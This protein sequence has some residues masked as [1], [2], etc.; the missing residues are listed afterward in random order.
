MTASAGQAF[1]R[2]ARSEVSSAPDPAPF[3]ET[4][5]VTHRQ[6]GFDLLKGVEGHADDDQQR[7][8]AE[9][10]GNVQAIFNKIW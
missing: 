2:W 4:L 5:V 1:G 10:K 6:L 9:V 3:E 8:P 7:R